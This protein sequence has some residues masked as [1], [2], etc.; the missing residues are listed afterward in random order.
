MDR[1][2]VILETVQAPEV[3]Q[4]RLPPQQRRTMILAAAR[5]CI[6][7]RGMQAATAREVAAYAGVTTGTIMHHFP[8]MAGLLADAL[9]E[10]SEQFTDRTLSAA[11]EHTGARARL[12]CLIDAN[13]PDRPESAQQWRLWIELWGQALLVPEL[14]GVHA[15]RHASQ[16]RALEQMLIEGV[17]QG[18]LEPVDC[19]QAAAEL[20]ALIDGLGLQAVIGD[21]E[22][23]SARARAVL[24]AWVDR[25]T[26]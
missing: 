3:K 11:R 5:R 20:L 14:A 6:A 21:S 9:R 19:G 7:E 26:T 1:P 16:R 25:L 23:T 22:M 15:E 4:R 13:L 18:Q 2:S 24:V 17:E 10:G 12:I 8:S